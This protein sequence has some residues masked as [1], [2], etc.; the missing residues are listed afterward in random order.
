MLSAE[1]I[2]DV[3][4]TPFLPYLKSKYLGK[5]TKYLG[6]QRQSEHYYSK[7]KNI[8]AIEE[9]FYAVLD[10]KK[11]IKF[12]FIKFETFSQ[13]LNNFDLDRSKQFELIDMISESINLRNLKIR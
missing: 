11:Q 10:S 12:S 1:D 5:Q 7:I 8:I 6:V 13:I 4:V 9:E 2:K 3:R